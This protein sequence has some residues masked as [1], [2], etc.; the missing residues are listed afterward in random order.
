[1]KCSRSFVGVMAGLLTA[2]VLSP[3]PA[4]GYRVLVG[5]NTYRPNLHPQPIQA[6]KLFACDGCNL[7]PVNSFNEFTP[8]QW[9]QIVGHCGKWVT[10]ESHYDN[11]TDYGYVA[12]LLGRQPNDGTI[13]IESRED[14]VKLPPDTKYN[15]PGGTILK[16]PRIAKYSAFRGG[17]PVGVMT[18]SY[19]GG[20]KAALDRALSNRKVSA[21]VMEY[22]PEN[23]KS[24]ML[25]DTIAAILRAKKRAYVL[26]YGNG[27]ILGNAAMIDRLNKQIPRE[28]ASD[29]V[30]FVVSNYGTKSRDK[31]GHWFNPYDNS[32]LANIAML[33]TR[34]NYRGR[35]GHSKSLEL[36][37]PPKSISK[38]ELLV[39]AQWHSGK[40]KFTVVKKQGRH[41]LLQFDSGN[42]FK[43]YIG[44]TFD[45]GRLNGGCGELDFRGD[46]RDGKLRVHWV[47]GNGTKF[48]FTFQPQ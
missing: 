33:K 41:V 32:V 40:S 46:L 22:T 48:D 7:M 15:E 13:Y 45:G 27:P 21:V 16:P 19:R 26:T 1:M 37:A 8:G 6:T 14:W 9:R 44:G 4:F 11:L 24:K 2:F 10:V 30:F 42:G 47:Q 23:Q 28:M 17:V 18:A 3:S 29:D 25:G 36:P 31:K 20:W 39:G 12:Q 35:R 43:I 5:L 34:K 38:T